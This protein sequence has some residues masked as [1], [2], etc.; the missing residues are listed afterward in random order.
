MLLCHRC[1]CC[2]RGAGIIVVVMLA[3]LPPP[4]GHC[5][6]RGA[7]I[8]AAI[9]LALLPL[10]LSRRWPH[11][12][13][14]LASDIPAN[15]EHCP[16]HTHVTASITLVSL[17]LLHPHHRQHC[18]GIFALV[19]LAPLPLSC[20]HHCPSHTRSHRCPYA[21]P[22]GRPSIITALALSLRWHRCQRCLGLVSVAA[23]ASS[24]T[25]PWHCCHC[26]HRGTGV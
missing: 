8:I 17:P 21:P 15:A 24:R 25:P 5:C 13:P 23:L 26:C 9:A 4:L 19:A 3:L 11:C 6:H 1:H 16:R 14:G 7:G 18:A 22:M 20:W 2:L 10:L 12:G